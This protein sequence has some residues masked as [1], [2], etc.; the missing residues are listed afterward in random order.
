M[1]YYLLYILSAFASGVFLAGCSELETNITQPKPLTVHKEGIS[2]PG[3]ANFHGKL[4]REGGWDMQQCKQCHAADFSGG[5]TDAS[6]NN[7]HTG[8]DGPESCNTCHGTF[9][10]PSRIAPPTD[11][12]NNISDTVRGVGAHA[13]HLYEYT[14]GARVRCSSCHFTPQNLYD[15]THMDSDGT[16]EVTLKNIAVA[17]GALN[18]QYNIAEASCSN[19]YCHG[20]FTFYRDSTA[21]TNRFAYTADRMTGTPVTMEWTQPGKQEIVCGSCHGLPPVGHIQVPLSS[22][23]TCHGEVVD[24]EGRIINKDKHIDGVADAR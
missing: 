8:N 10:D 12:D 1:K 19:T 3:H 4:I 7:C 21:E 23:Y 16:A 2:T 9:S 14:L 22:C 17:H 20:N 24:R 11:L 6:C 5:V 13:S 15:P 18:A